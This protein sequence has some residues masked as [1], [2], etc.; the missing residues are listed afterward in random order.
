MPCGDSEEG[1]DV[2][3]ASKNNTQ[4]VVFYKNSSMDC[5]LQDQ[6]S[7]QYPLADKY[8][9]WTKISSPAIHT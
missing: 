3:V 9:L 5:S 2:S 8:N 1:K 6:Y 7:N 4:V